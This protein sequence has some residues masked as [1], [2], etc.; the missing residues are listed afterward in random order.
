MYFDL[1]DF[2]RSIE[3]YVGVLVAAIHT[4]WLAEFSFAI[5]GIYEKSNDP[6]KELRIYW[7]EWLDWSTHSLGWR[8]IKLLFVLPLLILVT[9]FNVAVVL[10]K[11]SIWLAFLVPVLMLNVLFSIKFSYSEKDENR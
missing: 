1:E 10:F 5:G 3:W 6:L 2:V 8:I 9:A 11:F 7:L 4:S